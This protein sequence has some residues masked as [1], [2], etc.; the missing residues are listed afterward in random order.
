M[1]VLATS[2][3]AHDPDGNTVQTDG[4]I[5]M[6]CVDLETKK[7]YYY[8]GC[9]EGTVEVTEVEPVP[10]VEANEQLIFEDSQWVVLNEF[11]S[12]KLCITTNETVSVRAFNE[13]QLDDQ[14]VNT[15]NDVAVDQTTK[16]HCIQ[17]KTIIEAMHS[18]EV[19]VTR[20]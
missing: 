11:I 8:E 6:Q 1:G 4:T 5:Y 10:V 3:F 15:Q 12:E 18:L 17:Y 19:L 9:P 16:T 7:L 13:V 14:V 20:E 2:A